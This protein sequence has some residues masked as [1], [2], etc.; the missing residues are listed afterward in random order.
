M[1]VASADVPT[2][3]VWSHVSGTEWALAG[4]VAEFEELTFTPT[5]NAVGDWSITMP[6]T[7]QALLFTKGCLVTID[8]RS[9]R[10]TWRVTSINPKSD[11]DSG[12]P[13]LTVAGQGALGVLGWRLTWPDGSLAIDAQPVI[14]DTDPAP[15]KGAAETVIKTLVKANLRGLGLV[16]PPSTGVGSSVQARPVFDN[17]LELTTNQAKLG[18]IGIDVGLVNADGSPT[19]ADLTLVTWAPVDKSRSVLLT[20]EAGTLDEWEQVDGEPTATIALVGGSGPGGANR[21]F[22]WPVTT[23]ESVAAAAEWGGARE[24]FVDGPA[25]FDPTELTQAG[26]QALKDGAETRTLSF[27]SAETEAQRA[28]VD[29]FVGDK[30]TGEVLPGDRV[31]D[32]ITSVAVTFGSGGIT[33]APGFGDPSATDAQLDLA[34][35][36]GDLKRAM[37][38]LERK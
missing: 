26:E 22:Q 18:G 35:Q 33:V 10:S 24:V 6:Y 20:Q 30:A 11:P 15:Y 14:G 9:A 31:V 13:V 21:F 29:Y 2:L 8:W 5:L 1:I 25:S 16:V 36:I 4:Q 12:E 27:T 34:Q 38:R 32:V 19:R 3:S 37:R 28:F 17:M 23:D 7:E